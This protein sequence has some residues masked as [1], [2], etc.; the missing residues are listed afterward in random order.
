[1]NKESVSIID[2]GGA[3][4]YGYFLLNYYMKRMNIDI[5][6]DYTVVETVAMVKAAKKFEDGALKFIDTDSFLKNKDLNHEKTLIINSTLQYIPNSISILKSLIDTNNFEQIIINRTPLLNNN[7]RVIYSIQKNKLSDN[8][9]GKIDLDDDK[10][11]FYQM[12]FLPMKLLLDTLQEKYNC[13]VKKEDGCMTIR[14]KLIDMY[15]IHAKM[16]E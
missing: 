3:A 9:I 16:K 15:A 2:L 10:Y 1:M 11:I 14:G 7:E 12:I 5:K 6:L 8:G 13:T 4:G